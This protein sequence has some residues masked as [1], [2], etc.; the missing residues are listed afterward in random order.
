M[1]YNEVKN[2]KSNLIK[3]LSLLRYMI[4]SR[5]HSL[6][7]ICSFLLYSLFNYPMSLMGTHMNYMRDRMQIQVYV[8]HV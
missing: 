1:I 2:N 7:R 6:I 3:I 5:I 4:K 8:S